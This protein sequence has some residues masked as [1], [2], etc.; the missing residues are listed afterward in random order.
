MKKFYSTEYG[1]LHACKKDGSL[2]YNLTDLCQTL[3]MKL[4]EAEAIVKTTKGK[5]CELNVRRQKITSCNRY[6]DQNGLLSLLIESRRNQANGYRQWIESEVTYSL[7]NP[8][9]S[10]ELDEIPADRD[11]TSYEM[12]IAYIEQA[13][14]KKRLAEN[15]PVQLSLPI[16]KK[17]KTPPT[18]TPAQATTTP[19]T[20]TPPRSKFVPKDGHM[21]VEEFFRHEMSLSEFIGYLDGVLKDAR[22]RIRTLSQKQQRI[23]QQNINVMVVFRGMLKAN[24]DNL[25]YNQTS[26]IPACL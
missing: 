16:G 10:T 17:Q 4:R 15:S 6:V 3:A 22:Q 5:V 20:Q 18:G 8:D 11:M 7:L 13:R 25:T 9:H 19:K 14:K 1:F 23:A 24:A 26:E 2:W 12:R 21:S